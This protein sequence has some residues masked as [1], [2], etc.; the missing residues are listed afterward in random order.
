VPKYI[1]YLLKFSFL[2][3][4]ENKSPNIKILKGHFQKASRAKKCPRAVGW[5]PLN[6]ITVKA[7]PGDGRIDSKVSIEIQSQR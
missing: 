4:E 6:K 2:E 7:K 5:P 3:E 1:F